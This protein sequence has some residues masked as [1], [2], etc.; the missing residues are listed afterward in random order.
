MLQRAGVK[1]EQFSFMAGLGSWNAPW[2]RQLNNARWAAESPYTL[3]INGKIPFFPYLGVT[4]EVLGE[5]RG[6]D[7]NR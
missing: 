7:Q 4:A 2:E 6:K 1:P 3:R 5:L